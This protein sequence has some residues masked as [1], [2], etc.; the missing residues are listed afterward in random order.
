LSPSGASRSEQPRREFIQ[1][2]PQPRSGRLAP[3][4]KKR[5]MRKRGVKAG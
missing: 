2:A 4:F 1:I 3:M 5:V